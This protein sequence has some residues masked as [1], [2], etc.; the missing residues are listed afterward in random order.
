MKIGVGE[1][2][3]DTTRSVVVTVPSTGRFSWKPVHFLGAMPKSG[4]VTF[5]NMTYTNFGWTKGYYNSEN[6]LEVYKPKFDR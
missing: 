5:S 4:V 1:K 3:D 2:I 6:E